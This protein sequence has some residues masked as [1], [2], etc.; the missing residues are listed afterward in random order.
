VTRFR[1]VAAAASFLVYLLLVCVPGRAV[2]AHPSARVAS[3]A[4]DPLL[5][6]AVL[7]WNATHRPYSE[8][9]W[10]FP[11]FYP[12]ADTLAF[13]EH[14]LG[15]SVIATPVEWITGDPLVTYNLTTLLTFP[16]CAIAMY[17]LVME[18][19]GSVAAAFVA[20]LAYGFAPYRLSQ[21]PHLQMLASFWAPLALLGLHRYLR[22]SRIRWLV[23]Y[24]AAWALQGLAN[25]YA[26]VFLSVLIGL[27]GLWFVVLPGRWRELVTIVTTTLVAAVPIVP[28]L[29]KYVAVRRAYGFVRDI[30]E[31][32]AF[33]A[34][35][36][37]LLC[38]SPLLSLWGWLHVAC[39]PEGELFPGAAF[40]ALY[41]AG[42]AWMV[43][44]WRRAGGLLGRE[45]DGNRVPRLLVTAALISTFVGYA[46][47]LPGGWRTS[48]GPLDISA[49]RPF[50]P[51]AIAAG[52][53]AAAV[54]MSPRLRGVLRRPST[55]AFYV[56]ALFVMWQLALGPTIIVL[57]KR[58]SLAGPF[59]W[60]LMI[61]GVD[62]LR[63][64]ARFWQMAIL[65]GSVVIGLIVCELARRL[66]P[67]R[68]L[69]AAAAVV[70]GLLVLSDGWTNL[71]VWADAPRQAPAP[72]A[73][74]GGVVLELPIGDPFA[75]VAAQ[76]RAVI[77]GWHTVNGLSGYFPPLYGELVTQMRNRSDDLF[78]R[79]TGADDLNVIVD[80]ESGLDAFVARQPGAVL[81]ARSSWASQYRIPKR[82]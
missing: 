66:P 58:S 5:S 68:S 71:I 41:M 36:G 7:R 61:P 28:I 16:L 27:W 33:S 13:S 73:L 40:A 67:R 56:V 53:A 43:A 4:G 59:A 74:R 23:V 50:I 63:V 55:L 22:T 18:L 46:I 17:A 45:S 69:R 65:A 10:Q 6:A 49:H 25:G 15:V 52:L 44:S 26:L 57:G 81:L 32:R 21:L 54:S 14:F 51:F 8:A 29:L 9:W 62:G 12:A 11:N 80:R 38:A 2:L 35:A 64:P 75:D 70:L 47:L 31:I 39:R 30:E 79:F 20:G 24:G 76:Y 60:L 3:D 37:G 82:R 48:L 72:A 42:V 19:T 1:R 78:G 77:G 34:D